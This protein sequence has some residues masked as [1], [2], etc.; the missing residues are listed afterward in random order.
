MLTNGIYGQVFNGKATL[1]D[2]DLFERNTIIDLSDV[3]SQETISL[4]MGV[5]VVRLREY[6]TSKNKPDNRPLHHVMVLEEAHNIFQSK[7]DKNSEG[8][9]NISGKSVQM[10]SDCT[11]EM[12]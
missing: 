1:S 7:S 4:L 8:G 2:E 5:L 10:L 9:E 12:R 6:R 11:A 3:G